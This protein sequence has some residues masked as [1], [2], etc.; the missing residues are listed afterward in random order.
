MFSLEMDTVGGP[1]RGLLTRFAMQLAHASAFDLL[2]PSSLPNP[3]DGAR[4]RFRA[5]WMAT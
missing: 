2:L 5:E 4:R 3:R 1:M